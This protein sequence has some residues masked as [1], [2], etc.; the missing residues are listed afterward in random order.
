MSAK[1][2]VIAF[3]IFAHM[4]PFGIRLC[5]TSKFNYYTALL[6]QVLPT[7]TEAATVDGFQACILLLLTQF[8]TGKLRSSA[9]TN[10]IAAHFVFYLGAHNDCLTQSF[11][12]KQQNILDR[13]RTHLR[14]LFWACY[15]IDKDLCFRVLQPPALG[16]NHCDLNLSLQYLDKISKDFAIGLPFERFHPSIMFPTDIKLSQ[17][18]S[19]AYESLHSIA[20]FRKPNT[21]LFMDIRNLDNSLETWRLA[22]PENYRPSLSFSYDMEVDPGSIDMR[23]LM[24]RLD[25]LYCVTVIHRASNRCLETIMSSDGMETVIA[26]SIALAVEASRSTLRYLQT[27]YHVLNE[28][29]FWLIIF[30]TLAASVTI[31]CNILDNPALPSA[32]HDYELLKNVQRLMSHMSMQSIEGEE[33][34][35]RDQLESF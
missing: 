4:V 18:K 34:L 16:D 17:I 22:I 33:R 9:I 8:F 2:C 19:R 5:S 13:T 11:N 21:E 29:S 1:A 26:T 27:A 35:H 25:Y 7:I 10:S 20:A 12:Q 3:A 15:T 32:V 23:T 30:Y 14:N 31:M 28:G 6:Q 24:L